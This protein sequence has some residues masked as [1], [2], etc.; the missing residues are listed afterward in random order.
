M[1]VAVTLILHKARQCLTGS[2]RT[3]WMSSFACDAQHELVERR[4]VV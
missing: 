4:K 2:I 1:V 3:M